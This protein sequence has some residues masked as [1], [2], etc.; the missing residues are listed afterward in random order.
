MAAGFIYYSGSYSASKRQV[1]VGENF[2][3][4]DHQLV[5]GWRPYVR[6]DNKLEKIEK[7]LTASSSDR[8][9]WDKKK[10]DFLFQTFFFNIQ[11]FL[12]KQLVFSVYQEERKKKQNKG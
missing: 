5:L 11:E 8:S 10:K 6:N 1:Q 3:A 9:I 2:C 4:Y 7:K 12:Q